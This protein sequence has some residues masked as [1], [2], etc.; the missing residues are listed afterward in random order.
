MVKS[1]L[2]TGLIRPNF[3]SIVQTSRGCSLAQLCLTRNCACKYSHTSSYVFL[4]AKTSSF[5]DKDQCLVCTYILPIERPRSWSP[6][7]ES[8]L[9]KRARGPIRRSKRYSDILKLGSARVSTGRRV[10]V[11]APAGVY[12]CRFGNLPKCGEGIYIQSNLRRLIVSALVHRTTK[13]MYIKHH[14]CAMERYHAWSNDSVC[15]MG[16]IFLRF[17]PHAISYVRLPNLVV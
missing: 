11:C 1:Y 9:W 4:P 12:H 5:L 17:D 3:G 14:P 15:W 6:L 8:W 10:N 16:V 7:G 2:Y 13:P